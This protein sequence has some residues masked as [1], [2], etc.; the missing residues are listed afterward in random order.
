M[1]KKRRG[2]ANKPSARLTLVA[3]LEV[4]RRLR[5]HFGA[6]PWRV[7]REPVLDSLIGTILSQSTS[8][9]NSGRAFAQ[10]KETFPEWEQARRAPASRIEAA[11]RGGGLARMKSLRIKEI[12]ERLHATRGACSLEYLRRAPT[13][14]IKRELLELPGV[15]PKT[16]AC[17]LLFNLKR[18][19]FPVDTHIH[20]IAGR[21]GWAL[22]RASAED[23]YEL[24][25]PRVPERLTYELHVLLITHGRRLC[26]ARNPRCLDCPL[27]SRCRYQ[28]RRRAGTATDSAHRPRRITEIAKGRKR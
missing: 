14:R 4:H 7:D 10:L 9:V 19:D 27:W 28:R 16:V 11:I 6:R 23:V 2:R 21:L 12:L 8:D 25:N 13:E 20:R 15:G 5:R 17:V 18:P 26:R 3:L 1:S 22:A 24:L